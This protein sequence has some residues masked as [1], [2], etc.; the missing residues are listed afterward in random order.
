MAR[1]AE[2]QDYRRD[3]RL[4]VRAHHQASWGPTTSRVRLH[5]VP[6]QADHRDG[7]RAREVPQRKSDLAG[8]MT[9]DHRA[10]P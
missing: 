1:V 9:E 8:A 10:L 3:T 2:T 7:R 5:I 6:F 4:A